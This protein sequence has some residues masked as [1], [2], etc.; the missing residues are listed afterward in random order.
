VSWS[1]GF[2]AVLP[3]VTLMLR[4]GPAGR[5]AVAVAVAAGRAAL[6]V[7][8]AAGRLALAVAVAVAVAEVAGLW[9]ESIAMGIAIRPPAMIAPTCVFP[10]P[11]GVRT[12]DRSPIYK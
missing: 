2:T 5:R 3:S 12:D 7:A 4:S 1:P 11:C 10:R 9:P 6:A 8:V